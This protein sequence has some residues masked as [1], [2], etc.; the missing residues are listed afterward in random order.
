MKVTM[1]IQ[2]ALLV[3]G[4]VSYQI[5][6]GN[7]RAATE[8][9]YSFILIPCVGELLGKLP[10]NHNLYMPCSGTLRP[11]VV[12]YKAWHVKNNTRI[13]TARIQYV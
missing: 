2:Y 1:C 5:H 12:L 10:V 4:G 6:P 8:L 11:K 9:L 3:K 13:G 7:E